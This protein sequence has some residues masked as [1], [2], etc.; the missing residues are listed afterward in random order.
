M[1]GG[2]SKVQGPKSK[3][4]GRGFVLGIRAEAEVLERL[5]VTDAV[6]VKDCAAGG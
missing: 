2:K 6:G 1:A 5:I 3:V 4:Q